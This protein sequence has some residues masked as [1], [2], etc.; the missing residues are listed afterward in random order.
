MTNPQAADD[1]E[2]VVARRD[3]GFK[4]QV[5]INSDGL[6][7]VSS[8]KM[9]QKRSRC[10][11]CNGCHGCG[12]PVFDTMETLRSGP[13]RAKPF[14]N[15]I[16]TSVFELLKIGI[17]PS[18]S[19]TVGPMIA[20]R[21]FSK[22]LVA[23]DL[24]DS[25]ARVSVELRGSL[26]LT[27]IGH[28][29]NKACVMGLAG[30][31][32]SEV[33][34]STVEPFLKGVEERGALRVGFDASFKDVLFREKED[35][36]LV[37]EELPLHPNGMICRAF[38]DVKYSFYRDSILRRKLAGFHLLKEIR[39]YSTGGG[40]IMTEDE[41]TQEA[42]G[43]CNNEFS[44]A[45]GSDLPIPF[46]SMTDLVQKCKETGLDIAGVMRRNEEA[47]RSPEEVELALEEIW[48]V[49]EQCV[50][51]GLD[52]SKLGVDLPGPLGIV[53]RAPG[54]YQHALAE[55]GDAAALSGLMNELRWVDCYALAVMEE[56]AC[57]GR[58][59]TAPTN[60]ASGVVP[61]ILTYYMR[62][63]RPKQPLSKR[64]ERPASTYLLTAA[65]VGIMAKEHASI[66]GAAG[67]CQAEVG[68]ATAMAAAG[69]CAVMGGTPPQVDEA[70]E[71]ALEH[72][73]GMTCDP[74]AGLVQVPCIERNAMGSSKAVNAVALVLKSPPS[75]RRS[76]LSYDDVLRVMKA[77]GDD[78][79]AKYRETAEGG[80][81]A[82]FESSLQ[83]DRAR[84][85]EVHDMMGLARIRRNGGPKFVPTYEAIA[86]DL[87]ELRR[88]RL[89]SQALPKC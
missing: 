39:Y 74:V 14:F 60:G 49:M 64:P 75:I 59:V 31:A 23:D 16:S 48:A 19:H 18:S 84:Q 8:P 21:N 1:V 42:S 47:R 87:D 17:G 36:L 33:D 63:L 80:L 40:F 10:N 41:M 54:L 13:R 46:C 58:V 65:A 4:K 6:S 2:D 26:A 79:H 73:L 38:G 83:L 88:G 51:N 28:A 77:T 50:D 30:I 43:G 25:V 70:A 15:P 78:M 44:D 29:T 45:K 85:R 86:E 67:G 55:E 27:G 89:N 11:S 22:Q 3:I 62:H 7:S 66:S 53:R 56:N 9:S 69:L 52:D 71:I 82:D 61:A 57:M 34:P 20:C 37:A 35:V 68:T 76:M 12:I 5:S 32:P 81:A 72:C 24:L